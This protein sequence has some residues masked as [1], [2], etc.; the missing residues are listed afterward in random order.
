MTPAALFIATVQH[1]NVLTPAPATAVDKQAP[2]EAEDT[3]T[4]L[5]R[6]E[7]PYTDLLRFLWGIHH[8]EVAITT[9]TIGNLQDNDT[10]AWA[11]SVQV[12]MAPKIAEKVVTMDLTMEDRNGMSDGTMT[13][14]TKLSESIIRY[15]EA[16]AKV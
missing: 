9:L 5:K 2:D 3:D 11:A 14:M 1:I 10:V 16:A 12:I 6:I 4:I 13:A 15:Q 7:A 8:Y